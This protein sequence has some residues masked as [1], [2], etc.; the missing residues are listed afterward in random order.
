MD[1]NPRLDRGRKNINEENTG[2]GIILDYLRGTRELMV[3]QATNTRA[4]CREN[5]ETWGFV[6]RKGLVW[7]D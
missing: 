7:F 6:Q 5:R 1:Q 4:D 3:P 2:T